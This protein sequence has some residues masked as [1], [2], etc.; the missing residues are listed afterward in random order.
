[1]IYFESSVAEFGIT[2]A[3][4]LWCCCRSE[5]LTEEAKKE[6]EMQNG[7]TFNTCRRTANYFSCDALMEFLQRNDLSHVVRAHEVQHVGFRVWPI[8]ID[9]TVNF[10]QALIA[11]DINWC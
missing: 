10:T 6:L 4:H 5:K 11:R 7:F 3:G 1:M 9:L 2:N 8:F